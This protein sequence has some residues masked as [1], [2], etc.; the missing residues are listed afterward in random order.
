MEEREEYTRSRIKE[1]SYCI[2]RGRPPATSPAKLN[3]NFKKPQT[4]GRL[5]CLEGREEE[6]EDD[7]HAMLSGTIFVNHLSTQVLFNVGVTHS[8]INP[9]TA[10][11]LACKLDDMDMQLC[12]T[13][14]ADSM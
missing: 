6:T 11:R 13:T 14:P 7:P 10:N 1:P 12:V 4:G 2:A 3:R 8:F 9:A 5:Y